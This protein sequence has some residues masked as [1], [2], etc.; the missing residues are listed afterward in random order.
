MSPI[1]VLLCVG[2]LLSLIILISIEQT[3]TSIKRDIK[4]IK[5]TLDKED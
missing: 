3:V 5:K 2:V 1:E 4:G